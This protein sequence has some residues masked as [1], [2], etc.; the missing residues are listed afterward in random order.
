MRMRF[1]TPTKTPRI[2]L[3][4]P[5][6]LRETSF[7][8]VDGKFAGEFTAW[9]KLAHFLDARYDVR[10]NWFKRALYSFVFVPM[11]IDMTLA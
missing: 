1:K 5:C 6:G 9:D 10:V 8:M 3:S 4:A 11:S 2:V 7:L